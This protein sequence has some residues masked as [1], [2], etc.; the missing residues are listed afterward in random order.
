MYNIKQ[1]T[2]FV[3]YFKYHTVSMVKIPSVSKELAASL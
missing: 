1:I 2:F 3:H